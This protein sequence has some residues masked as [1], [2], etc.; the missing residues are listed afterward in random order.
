[1]WFPISGTAAILDA[2]SVMRALVATAATK[3]GVVIV[4]SP[5]EEYG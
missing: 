3:P 4:R 2:R 5:Y 1:M